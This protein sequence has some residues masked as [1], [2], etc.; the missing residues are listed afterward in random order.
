MEVYCKE[1]MCP[2]CHAAWIN[3]DA[4]DV[5]IRCPFCAE[6]NKPPR[7]GGL[8]PIRPQPE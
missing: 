3:L 4:E 5:P 2:E 1:W 7:P 8:K 6:E